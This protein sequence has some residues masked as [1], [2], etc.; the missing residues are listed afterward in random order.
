M[1]DELNSQLSAF[2]TKA[3]TDSSIMG[4]LKQIGRVWKVFYY[5]KIKKKTVVKPYKTAYRDPKHLVCCE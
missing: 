1:T 2:Y 4:I 3:F 5:A